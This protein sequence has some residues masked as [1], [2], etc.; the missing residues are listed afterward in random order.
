M[1]RQLFG[2]LDHLLLLE[3]TGKDLW[4]QR[5]LGPGE[6]K[7]RG[8]SANGVSPSVHMSLRGLGAHYGYLG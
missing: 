7:G 3:E 8:D 1:G 5:G 2:P 4:E 6:E